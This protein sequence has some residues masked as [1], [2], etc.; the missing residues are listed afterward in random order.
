MQLRIVT[1][2][3]IALDGEVLRI[4]AEAPNGA[5]GLLPGMW[6]S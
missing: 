3:T 4:V 5:F 1:P 6:I 2:T